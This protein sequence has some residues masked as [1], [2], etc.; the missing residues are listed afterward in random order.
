MMP[1]GARQ[2]GPS[3]LRSSLSAAYVVGVTH[4]FAPIP[5]LLEELKAGRPIVL[6]D[7]PDRENEGDLCFAAEF[8]T[9]ELVAQMS[10][11]AC[12]LKLS[13]CESVHPSTWNAHAALARAVES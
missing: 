10:R 4:T 1:A 13:A 11:E 12:G 3:P 2:P 6:V 8:A 7:D 5:E 9:P